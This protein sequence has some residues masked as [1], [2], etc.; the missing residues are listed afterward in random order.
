MKQGLE[1]EVVLFHLGYSI[2][3]GDLREGDSTHQRAGWGD[4]IPAPNFHSWHFP[5]LKRFAHVSSSWGCFCPLAFRNLTFNAKVCGA[6]EPRSVGVAVLRPVIIQSACSDG[7]HNCRSL[8]NEELDPQNS[9]AE[10]ETVWIFVVVN[11][12][13]LEEQNH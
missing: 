7:W 8:E 6:E 9:L 1:G 4:N 2:G 5:F 3:K 13:A 11:E 10:Q 12:K